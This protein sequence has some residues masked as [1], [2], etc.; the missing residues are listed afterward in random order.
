MQEAVS[1]NFLGEIAVESRLRGGVRNRP[2]E[3]WLAS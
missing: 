1:S 2:V 3:E